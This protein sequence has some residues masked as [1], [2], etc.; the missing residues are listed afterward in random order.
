LPQENS[1]KTLDIRLLRRYTHTTV[2]PIYSSRY[3]LIRAILRIPTQDGV[4]STHSD[5]AKIL[6]ESLPRHAFRRIVQRFTTIKQTQQKNSHHSGGLIF[7]KTKRNRR[8]LSFI[9]KN[10]RRKW[11]EMEKA[12]KVMHFTYW[13]NPFC[14]YFFNDSGWAAVPTTKGELVWKRKNLT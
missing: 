12:K 10:R 2:L 9:Y 14:Y 5:F 6:R 1:G 11:A 4:C 7:L 8:K 3:T 13:K